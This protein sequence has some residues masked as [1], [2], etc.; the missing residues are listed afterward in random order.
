M[1]ISGAQEGRER[2]TVNVIFYQFV[3]LMFS[4]TM[5]PRI[6]RTKINCLIKHASSLGNTTVGSFNRFSWN[7][8]SNLKSCLCQ[9][10]IFHS[11]LLLKF[12]F[13]NV[14][15]L[16]DICPNIRLSVLWFDLNSIFI[17]TKHPLLKFYY[18]AVVRL[19]IIHQPHHLHP[20]NKR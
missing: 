18:Q 20:F 16:S 7:N 3:L 2:W 11:N 12:V 9:Q 19:T 15:R 4:V 5:T 13:K 8:K 6:I 17:P 14:D 10:F 1:Y